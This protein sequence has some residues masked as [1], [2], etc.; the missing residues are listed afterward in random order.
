[1]CYVLHTRAVCTHPSRV[2][3]YEKLL[4]GD[5]VHL[6]ERV[7]QN[8]S[9]SKRPLRFCDPQ[10]PNM[11]NKE[12]FQTFLVS[13]F[14][15]SV[16]QVYASWYQEAWWS[17]VNPSQDTKCVACNLFWSLLTWVSDWLE[18]YSP[19]FVF[20]RTRITM[21]SWMG[22]WMPSLRAHLTMKC[23]KKLAPDKLCWHVIGTK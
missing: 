2:R 12:Y 1:M 14:S 3:I 21:S 19:F 7:P 16:L 18:R 8:T 13:W 6:H 10:K 15:K 9:W 17:N 22:R 23:E 20:T 4:L 11:L 5:L